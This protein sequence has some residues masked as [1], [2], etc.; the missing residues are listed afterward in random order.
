MHEYH[1]T[2]VRFHTIR[3]CMMYD[4]GGRGDFF[5][6]SGGDDIHEYIHL[7]QRSCA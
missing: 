7:L 6:D 1:D 3:G 5:D 4:D 2:N